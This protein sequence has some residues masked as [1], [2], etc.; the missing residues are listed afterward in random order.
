MNADTLDYRVTVDDPR[1]WTRPWT[2]ALRLMRDPEYVIHEY[3]CHEGNYALPNM[4]RI[5]RAA[6]R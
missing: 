4:L 5:S 3:A 6:E 1:T 2:V